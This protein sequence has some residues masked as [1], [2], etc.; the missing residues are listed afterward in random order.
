MQK[1]CT[2]VDATWKNLR[3]IATTEKNAKTIGLVFAIQS[4]IPQF[5]FIVEPS[6][7]IPRHKILG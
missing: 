6:G 1:C 2:F 5:I 7:F 3:L 4:F